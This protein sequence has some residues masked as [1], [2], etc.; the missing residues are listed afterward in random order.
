MTQVDLTTIPFLTPG[1]HSITVKAT[2]LGYLDS[3]AS[4]AVTVTIPEPNFITSESDYFMTSDGYL[5]NV[6]EG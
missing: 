1:E 6:Q 5:F 4:N 2:G 3:E